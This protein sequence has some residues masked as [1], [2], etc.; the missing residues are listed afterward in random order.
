MESFVKEQERL[1]CE[2]NGKEIGQQSSVHPG[3]DKTSGKPHGTGCQFFLVSS[4]T[5]VD[6]QH[7]VRLLHH[8]GAAMVHC[9]IRHY[10]GVSIVNY[11]F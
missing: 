6:H 2:Q 5:A 1:L 4:N 8:L 7:A 11:S 3:K 10:S 9:L